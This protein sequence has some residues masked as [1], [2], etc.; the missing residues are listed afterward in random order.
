MLKDKT[1]LVTGATGFI[2]LNVVKHLLSLDDKEI[3]VTTHTHR[4]YYYDNLLDHEKVTVHRVDLT[5][6]EDCIKV[7]L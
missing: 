3:I 6:E 1:I 7:T 4:S 2:G 5:K